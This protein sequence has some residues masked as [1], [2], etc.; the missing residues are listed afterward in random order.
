MFVQ[1]VKS[2]RIAAEKQRM[3]EMHREIVKVK[4]EEDVA[5]ADRTVRDHSIVG[6]L[7]DVVEDVAASEAGAPVAKTHGAAYSGQTCLDLDL[8]EANRRRAVPWE[9]AALC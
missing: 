4:I 6:L 8:E 7:E 3:S 5:T 1:S 9:A 2:E